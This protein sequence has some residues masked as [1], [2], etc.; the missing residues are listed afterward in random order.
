M[1]ACW[2]SEKQRK[3]KAPTKPRH[4]GPGF[5]HEHLPISHSVAELHRFSSEMMQ[6]KAVL[7]K[8]ICGLKLITTSAIFNN[9]RLMLRRDTR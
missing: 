5:P 1:K 6:E 9:I 4:S 7:V 8:K 2:Q 3:H